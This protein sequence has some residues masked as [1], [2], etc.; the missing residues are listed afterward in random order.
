MALF[1][2]LTAW[3]GTPGSF[4]GYV[5]EGAHTRPGWVYIQSRND[6]L[7]LVNVAAATVSYGDEIPV[8]LRQA[9]PRDSLRSGAEVRVLAE[10]D[11]SGNWQAQE[12]EILRLPPT[13][14]AQR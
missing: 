5:I 2:G 12:V 13:R 11:R 14:R 8:R 10:Q 7:R 1:C 6:M 9:H 4:R 3:A